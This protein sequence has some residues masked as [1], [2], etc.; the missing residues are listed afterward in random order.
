[1]QLTHLARLLQPDQQS[2]LSKSSCV[3]MVDETEIALTRVTS[4]TT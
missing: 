4:G 3:R 2:T 1:M